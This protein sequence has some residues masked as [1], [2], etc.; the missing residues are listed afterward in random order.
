[1]IYCRINLREEIFHIP[2][3][4]QETVTPL[5]RCGD[6]KDPRLQGGYSRK[7]SARKVIFMSIFKD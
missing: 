5:L 3:E 4:E 7:I 6:M 1:M 2:T